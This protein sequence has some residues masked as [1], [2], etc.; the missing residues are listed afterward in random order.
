MLPLEFS[1][2]IFLQL[3]LSSLWHLETCKGTAHT[4]LIF[5]VRELGDAEPM[6]T[7]YLSSRVNPEEPQDTDSL[8]AETR[9]DIELTERC[10]NSTTTAGNNQVFGGK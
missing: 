8:M 10:R 6:S 3:A 2:C 9:Q 5:P 1:V 7:A 4:G